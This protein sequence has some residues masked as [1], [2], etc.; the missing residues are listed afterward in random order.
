ML[1]NVLEGQALF[2]G[3]ELPVYVR[4][5][6]HAGNIYLDLC[7]DRVADRR[8]DSLRAGAWWIPAPSSFAVCQGCCHYP[9]R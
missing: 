5:A 4:L 2:D 6:D 1:L 9:C 3:P 8:S 7:N